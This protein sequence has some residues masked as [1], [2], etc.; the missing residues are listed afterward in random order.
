MDEPS[1]LEDITISKIN[2]SQKQDKYCKI[3]LI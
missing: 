3:P 2:Q 1:G